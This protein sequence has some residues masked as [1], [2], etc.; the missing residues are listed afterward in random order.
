[1]EFICDKTLA[2]N[3]NPLEFVKWAHGVHQIEVFLLAKPSML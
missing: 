2:S 3:G 1:M